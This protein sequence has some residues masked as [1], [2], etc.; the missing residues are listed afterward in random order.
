MGLDK[1]TEFC[2][3]GLFLACNY[4]P[5]M[6]SVMCSKCC[7]SVSVTLSKIQIRH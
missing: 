6:H 7:K 2:V 3:K 4:I 1:G 5:D